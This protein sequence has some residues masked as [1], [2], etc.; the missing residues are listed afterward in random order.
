M[1]E[2]FLS[3]FF[4]GTW[5]DQEILGAVTGKALKLTLRHRLIINIIA[6]A[7]AAATGSYFTYSNNAPKLNL[8]TR[9]LLANCQ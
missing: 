1:I 5:Q 3:F 4:N 2:F 9:S 6:S 8:L 7:V